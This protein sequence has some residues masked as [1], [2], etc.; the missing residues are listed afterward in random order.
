[1]IRRI[2]Y[3]LNFVLST[4]VCCSV[5]NAREATKKFVLVLD[6]GHGGNDTGAPGAYAKEK[7]INLNVVLELGQLV[8][9][10]C[11]DVRVIYTRKS[12]VFIPLNERAN[13]ANRAKAD[14]FISVHTNALEGGKIAY[15]AETYTLGMAKAASNLDVAKR[16]NAVILVEDNYKERYAG[17]NPNSA[18]SYIIFEF[19]Q[20]QYMKQSVSLATMIQKQYVSEAGRKDKGVHQAGFLVLRNT[21]MPSVLTELGFI[22]TPEEERFLSSEEGVRKMAY[23]IFKGFLNYKRT[24][25][26]IPPVI[27]KN[28]SQPSNNK[29]ETD[30]NQTP[31]VVPVEIRNQERPT[32]LVEPVEEQKPEPKRREQPA[33]EKEQ[34][35]ADKQETKDKTEGQPIFKIQLLVSNKKLA[36]KSPQFKGVNPIQFYEEGGLIKYTY[37]ECIEYPQIL[38]LKKTIAKLFP[39]AFVVAFKDGEKMELTTAI[40]EARKK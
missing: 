20:D 12:D 19:M 26:G 30:E 17:F 28:E 38:Q 5:V 2:F 7:N 13:I 24:Q 31:E 32:H 9:K 27:V 18:E 11:N 35:T 23:S 16:E 40:R 36:H 33:K 37:G 15:G 1:M 8:E 22:S 4:C 29:P 39:G 3:L 34:I 21:S 14:L 10:N 25:D 6:A